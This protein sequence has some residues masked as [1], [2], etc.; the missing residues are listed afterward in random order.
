MEVTGCGDGCV[1]G[2]VAGWVD[3]WVLDECHSLYANTH[4]KHEYSV[5]NSIWPKSGR[6][7]FGKK[8][9]FNKAVNYSINQ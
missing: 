9:F 8:T 2:D 3:E 1:F 7:S 5:L 6:V 4:Y